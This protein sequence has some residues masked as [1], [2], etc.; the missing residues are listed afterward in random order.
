VGIAGSASEPNCRKWISPPL[1]GHTITILVDSKVVSGDET[2]G[3][4]TN[5]TFRKERGV[6]GGRTADP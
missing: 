3:R 2:A 5:A 4:T 6:P 1:N